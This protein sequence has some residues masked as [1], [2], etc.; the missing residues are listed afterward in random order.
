MVRDMAAPGSN[1]KRY[2]HVRPVGGHW[3]VEMRV[4]KGGLG[5]PPQFIRR[6]DL[7]RLLFLTCALVLVG[8]EKSKF[9]IFNTVVS[10]AVLYCLL[11]SIL[12]RPQNL[13]ACGQR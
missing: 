13:D 3:I 5:E 4:I 2:P 11:M 6:L 1:V 12:C 9:L 7:M 8:S 10:V